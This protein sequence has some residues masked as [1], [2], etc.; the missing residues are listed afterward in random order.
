MAFTDTEI[1]RLTEIM[2]G[3][4][5]RAIRAVLDDPK[6]LERFWTG[7]LTAVEEIAAKRTGGLVLGAIGGLLSKLGLFLVLAGVVYAL[8]GWAAV[9]KLWALL[10]QKGN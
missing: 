9:P 2:A 7:G 4:N 5:E 1:D 8:A 3:A 10:G 6:A